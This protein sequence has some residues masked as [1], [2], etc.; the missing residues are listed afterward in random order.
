M[1]PGEDD[2]LGVEDGEFVIIRLVG[3]LNWHDV[4]AVSYVVRRTLLAR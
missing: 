1:F 2:V 3:G 4:F